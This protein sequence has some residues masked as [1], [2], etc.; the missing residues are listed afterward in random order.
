MLTLPL[1]TNTLPNRK[2]RK[3]KIRWMFSVEI[4]DRKESEEGR[5]LFSKQ[6]ALVPKTNNKRKEEGATVGVCRP[7]CSLP[8]L[9]GQSHHLS[10]GRTGSV[11]PRTPT[12]QWERVINYRKCPTNETRN[13]GDFQTQTDWPSKTDET[14][15][16]MQQSLRTD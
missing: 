3:M 8:S 5:M 6:N 13:A 9:S 12:K 15:T 11:L 16:K 10:L 14:N 4:N 7:F 2:D 1:Y